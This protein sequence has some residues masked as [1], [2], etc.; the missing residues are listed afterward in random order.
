MSSGSP[1]SMLNNRP[2]THSQVAGVGA[3]HWI[4]VA[5]FGVRLTGW[6]IAYGYAMTW[7]AALTLGGINPHGPAVL[8]LA[9][10]FLASVVWLPCATVVMLVRLRHSSSPSRA[11]WLLCG[12]N[13]VST[14]VFLALNNGR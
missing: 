12:A 10:L 4:D 3:G 6:P 7:L 11:E 8:L 9:A 5:A 1:D 13:A 2:R 14:G